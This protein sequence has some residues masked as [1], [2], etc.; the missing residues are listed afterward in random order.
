MLAS[1]LCVMARS[2]LKISGATLATHGAMASGWETAGIGV[3]LAA[4]GIA[5]SSLKAWAARNPKV[6]CA[7]EPFLFC[8]ED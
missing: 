5:L 6:K 2:L 3:A 4:A 8:L 1:Q 7:L